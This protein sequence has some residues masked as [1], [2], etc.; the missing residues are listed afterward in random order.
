MADSEIV[1]TEIQLN[2]CWQQSGQRWIVSDTTAGIYTLRAGNGKRP[3][4]ILHKSEI[5]NNY[6]KIR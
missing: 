3:D 4:R 1:K 6:K 5:L 2:S